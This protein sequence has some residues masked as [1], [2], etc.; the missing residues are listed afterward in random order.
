M[1]ANMRILVAD[2][3]SAS[4]KLLERALGLWG[5]RSIVARSDEEAV[6]LM[7]AGNVPSLALIDAEMLG[8]GRDDV[9]R[10]LGALGR[11]HAVYVLALTARD[12]YAGVH[13]CLEAGADDYLT[14]PI[15]LRELR[16]RLRAA[17]RFLEL[18][19]ELTAARDAIERHATRDELTGVMNRA[20]ALERLEEEV[21]RARRDMLGLAIALVDID[22][23]ELIHDAHGRPAADDVLIEMSRRIGAC[24]RPYDVVARYGG[25]EFLLVLPGVDGD[26][27]ATAAERVRAALAE[28]PHRTRSG[29]VTV[30]ASI[31]VATLAPR[32]LDGAAALVARADRA[33][34]GAKRAG[35]NRV[36]RTPSPA[37]PDP[38]RLTARPRIPS[39]S[40][41]AAIAD[42]DESPHAGHS[43]GARDQLDALV[44]AVEKE[45][46][47]AL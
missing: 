30:T 32:T 14:K 8:V 39:D 36:G 18:R 3:D 40:E 37:A 26:A 42:E 9:C 16:L 22:H 31:G 1:S 20:S 13:R 35:R 15:D 10:V 45:L 27:A 11:E 29:D 28:T 5:F 38:E 47:P 12:D 25:D 4:R 33:L 7:S 23:F 19:S 41:R 46:R 6:R 21:A 44:S 43:P 2:D 34:G 24:L 17:R